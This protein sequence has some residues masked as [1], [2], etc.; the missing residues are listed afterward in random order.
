MNTLRAYSAAANGQSHDNC[1]QI[2]A[3]VYILVHENW[4]RERP[5]APQFAIYRSIQS[6]SPKRFR[7][8]VSFNSRASPKLHGSPRAG[9]V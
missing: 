1:M 6:P 3:V 9:L 2:C 7:E 4:M 5:S 8:R